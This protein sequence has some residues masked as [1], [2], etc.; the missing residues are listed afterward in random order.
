MTGGPGAFVVSDYLIGLPG[1]VTFNRQMVP[2]LNV[3]WSLSSI[4]GDLLAVVSDVGVKQGSTY[5]WDPDGMPVVGT[6]QPDLTTGRFENGWLGEQQRMTD[7]SDASN[8]IVEMGARV[9]LPRLGRFTTPDPVEGGVGDSDYIYPPDPINGSDLS[10]RH[11][12]GQGCYYIPCSNYPNGVSDAPDDPCSENNGAGN[13]SMC[14]NPSIEPWNMTVENW[15]DLMFGIVLN[16]FLGGASSV[17]CTAP[18]F[19]GCA[20]VAAGLSYG[21]SALAECSRTGS[22]R[23]EVDIKSVVVGVLVERFGTGGPVIQSA[24][25]SVQLTVI[26]VT[27]ALRGVNRARR[28]VS[29]R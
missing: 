29:G 15:G 18:A 26:G 12:D 10:G 23:S 6:S 9:Y 17:A 5:R 7:T 14:N 22:C 2:L 8:P 21:I 25:S 1:G 20:W 16:L 13:P 24:E 4:H 11:H 28:M 27:G 19:V 3:R